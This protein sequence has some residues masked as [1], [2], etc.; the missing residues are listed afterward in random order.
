MNKL[1]RTKI[2]SIIAQTGKTC[3][4]VSM[5]V[6]SD[7]AKQL[8][9]DKLKE[10]LGELLEAKSNDCIIEE[11]ADLVEVVISYLESHGFTT[12][13]LEKVREAKKIYYGGFTFYKG[14]S[15][16][17]SVVK[18]LSVGDNNEES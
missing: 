12:D 11:A 2:P 3:E 16:D 7:E 5:W 1:V 18:L 14:L 9:K 17:K 15:R 13:D 4:T 6:T 10:E 8:L